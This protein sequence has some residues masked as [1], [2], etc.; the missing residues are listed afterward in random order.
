MPA[1]SPNCI[2][3]SYHDRGN[4]AFFEKGLCVAIDS[5]RRTNPGLPIFLLH[6][7]LSAADEARLTGCTPVRIDS[8]PFKEGGRPDLTVGAYFKLFA[9][10]F[11]RFDRALYLDSDLVVLDR[12]DPLFAGGGWLA[13]RHEKY[14]LA[15]EFADPARVAREEG[16]ADST[17]MMNSGVVVFDPKR[18]AA[19]NLLERAVEIGRA[20]GWNF[21]KNADQ[22]V[23]NILARRRGGFRTFSIRYNFCRWPDMEFGRTEGTGKTGAGFQA[24]FVPE[25]WRRRAAK[26]GFGPRRIGGPKA[27]IVHWNGPVKPWQFR[28]KGEDGR[29]YFLE[30][31]EQF[32]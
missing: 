22:G 28:E 24:P 7:G 25:G 10:E 9:G 21:F 29:K 15:H 27:A 16:L 5:V 31:Y 32:A 6:D 14:D 18:W 19:E 26:L 11:K 1:V 2:F 4:R 8:S 20:Y 13:A 3:F 23:L 17:V 12:L 30:C